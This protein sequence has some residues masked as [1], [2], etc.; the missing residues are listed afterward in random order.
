MVKA[1]K[2]IHQKSLERF[3]KNKKILVTGGTGSIGSEIIRQ[4]VRLK[5]AQIRVYSRDESKHFFLERELEDLGP[6]VDVRFLIGDIRD[7]ERLDKGLG[8]IDYVFHA[9]ALKH[10][11]Y[12][13]YNPFEAIKTNVYGA[14]N[15]IDLAHLHNVKK[16]IGIS[17]D[18]AVYPN[19]IMGITKL[20]MER[21]LISSRN[22]AGESTTR[23]SVVRFGNVLNSRGSVIPLWE[24]QIKKGGPVTVTDKKMK[25]FFIAIPDAVKLVLS[26]MTVMIGE[27]VFTIN[28][29]EVNIYQLAEKTIRKKAKGRKIRIKITGAREREKMEERL[30]TDEE[31]KLII[32]RGPFK[33]V[34]PSQE[35]YDDRDNKYKEPWLRNLK[36]TF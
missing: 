36:I 6:K 7:K 11:P 15:L 19:T 33:I 12:C 20:L 28:M 1:N 21:M 18:K 29:P 31:S 16:I 22:Y 26:A 10:V 4:L 3:F 24:D 8:G 34:L 27:E 35:I 25:R 17:T 14:Q 5:P 32:E 2:N 23:F 13:E 30:Y 9:A